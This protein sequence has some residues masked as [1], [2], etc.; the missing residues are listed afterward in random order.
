MQEHA[1]VLNLGVGH[2]PECTGLEKNHDLEQS[3][4]HPDRY[5]STSSLAEIILL[6]IIVIILKGLIFQLY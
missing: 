4:V 5:S 6:L 1:Y 3:P 2:G